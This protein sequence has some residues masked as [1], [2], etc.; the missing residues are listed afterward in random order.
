MILTPA[1][2]VS[3]IFAGWSGGGCTGTGACVFTVSANTSATAT[4]NKRP[5]NLAVTKSGTGNGLVASSPI[6]IN[7]GAD[8]GETYLYGDTIQLTATP[9]GFSSF[10]SWSGACTGSAGCTLTLNGDNV[11][12]GNFN[13][14]PL[15]GTWSG[16]TSQSFPIS[17]VVSG[18]KLQSVTYKA[19]VTGLYCSG[20]F[21]V[22]ATFGGALDIVSNR[23]HGDTSYEIFD[24]LFASAF[25]A[26][27]T[28]HII[29]S[30]CSGSQDVT[31][32]ATRPV[33]AGPFPAPAMF[34]S[35]GAGDEVIR[36]PGYIR[37][38]RR[39]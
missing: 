24:G 2:D 11:V 30:Y 1:P 28:L 27:G 31:W 12:T 34:S 36:G 32:T 38:I 20:T 25:G 7:C 23:F 21:T 35:S 33:G 10:S 5:V 8:C 26:N 39:E 9:D 4:F 13:K 16:T 18:D 14:I 17:F 6:G 19:H 15:N 37:T 29:D 22:T 3:S